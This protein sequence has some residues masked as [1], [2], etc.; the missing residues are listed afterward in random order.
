MNRERL[1]SSA[2]G[3]DAEAFLTLVQE[4][5]SS[6]YRTARAM[7]AND[8]DCADALQETILKAYRAVGGLKEPAFFKTWLYRILINECTTILRRRSKLSLPGEL[9]EKV[10]VSAEYRQIELRE[11]VDRLKE[12]LRL[13]VVLVY[14]EDMKIAEAA[15]VLGVSEGTVKMRLKRSRSQLKSW[16]EAPEEGERYRETAKY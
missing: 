13:A 7:L 8:E 15:R 11:A 10:E 6:M 9:P 3:G 4:L 2:K 5:K 14:M 1:A 12:P 16:L